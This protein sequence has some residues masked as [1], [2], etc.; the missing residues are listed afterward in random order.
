[1]LEGGFAWFNRLTE[2]L[3][4]D[5]YKQLKSDSCIF[6]KYDENL[7]IC[8]IIAIYVDDILYA[9]SKERVMNFEELLSKFFTVKTTTD[10]KTYIGM[11]MSKSEGKMELFS[12]DY[13]IQMTK[14]FELELAKSKKVPMSDDNSVE[15]KESEIMKDQKKF[16]QIVGVLS[17]IT[18][19]TRPDI[20]YAVNWLARKSNKATVQDFK[21]A[22]NV[23]V[24]LRETKET[25]LPIYKV[26]E[27]NN[28]ITAF[29]DSSFA[30]AAKRHSVYG[31][32]IYLNG[33]IIHYRSKVHDFVNLS[34]CEA[35]YLALAV[36]IKE[37]MWIRNTL[38]ELQVHIGETKVL[39]D[40]QG[41]ILIARDP[42]A[43]G[44]TRY[45]DINLQY[46]KGI[47]DKYQ[48]NLE[49][50]NTNENT[51]DIF[52]K[53]LASTKFNYLKD[54]LFQNKSTSTNLKK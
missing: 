12:E 41:A 28:I 26:K 50:V 25:K 15:N 39:C 30:N 6:I 46:L 13:I 3:L 9:G 10:L 20:A 17:Y 1:M 43:V 18:F 34:S 5:G 21:K 47:I 32:V 52:T 37:V 35:E 22:K 49:Y 51:A 8:I 31:L 40:N 36:T 45:L 48:I 53:A 27:R 33:S 29:V 23:L 54:L 2:V 19:T 11:Q 42:G 16:Q 38:R 7:K 24:Y 44:R 4:K 14:N